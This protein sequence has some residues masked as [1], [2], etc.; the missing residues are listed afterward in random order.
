MIQIIPKKAFAQI[1][2]IVNISLPSSVDWFC[3]HCHRNVNFRMSWSVSSATNPVLFCSSICSGCRK[4][5]IFIYVGFIE[6]QNNPREGELYIY[7][8]PKTRNPLSGIF[9]CI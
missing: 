6:D 9:E 3:P 2:T 8:E 4:T 1:R 5:S 7:P